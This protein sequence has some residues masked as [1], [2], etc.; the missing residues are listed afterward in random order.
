MKLIC[1][2]KCSTCKKAE[3]FLNDNNISYEYRDIVIETPTYKEL[4]GLVEKYNLDIKKMFNKSGLK[5]RTLNL[6]EE[7]DTYSDDEKLK[8]LA[9]DGMLIK[10]PLLI[11]D[12][13][14]LQGFRKDKW[15]EVI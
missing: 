12:N 2:P 4:K 6:K 9:S 3:K 11:G 13:F 10:R 1:Y 15:E 8:L 7:L 5:Y 14:V